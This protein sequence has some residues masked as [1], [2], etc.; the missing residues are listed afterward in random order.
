MSKEHWN[1]PEGYRVNSY[2]TS[3]GKDFYSDR[4]F[5]KHRTG[6]HAYTYSEGLK[7]DPP[8]EDG[9]RCMDEEE[10]NKIGMRPMTEQ[11]MSATKRHAHRIGYGIE[12]WFDPIEHAKSQEKFSKA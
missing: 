3:C 5:D 9:R 7:L 12:M 6:I 11:E 1:T 2:C 8:K 10:M 4:L